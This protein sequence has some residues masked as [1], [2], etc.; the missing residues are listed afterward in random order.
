MN[1]TDAVAFVEST[2]KFGS[3]PGLESTYRLMERLGNPQDSLRVIHVAGTNGKGSTSTFMK[4]ILMEAGYTVG[5]FTSPSLHEFTERIVVNNEEIGKD[6]FAAVAGEVKEAIDGIVADGFEANTEFEIFTAMAYLQFQRKGVDFAIMEVGMG[7]RL[8][9]TNVIKKPVV[10]VITPIALDHT[11][12]LGNTLYEI[13]G[14]KG[15]IIKYKCP[16]VLHPQA[17]E[18]EKRL[19][20]IAL[21]H[22]APMLVAPVDM[23]EYDEEDL[24][25]TSFRLGREQYRVG[26][27]GR[28]QPANAT[29]AMTAVLLL[30]EEEGITIPQSALKFGL[31]K[32][33]WAG[34]L[35]KL[36]ESPLILID[37]AHNPHGA[38]KLAESVK[39]LG[40]GKRVNALIGM[41][42]DKDV[43][44]VLDTML[45]VIHTAVVTE[46]ESDR[47]LP[48]KDLFEKVKAR[49]VEAEMIED[50]NGA[51]ERALLNTSKDDVLLVFGSFYLIGKLRKRIMDDPSIQLG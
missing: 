50:M 34:R 40:G 45:P 5:I 46:P 25:G 35:E 9:A 24:S 44:A 1:Y 31:L 48:A 28:H 22:E 51:L 42:G 20:E 17:E 30:E 8:D 11:D 2:L 13:A 47:K 6:D 19:Q 38:E 32:A 49:G 21:D 33:R 37:G 7:G 39:T 15:G 27:L 4:Q 36:S 23:I 14:E 26:M 16:V 43:D 12:W 29:V 10:T 41:L 3:R 18:A